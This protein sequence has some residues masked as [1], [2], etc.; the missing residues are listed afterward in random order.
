MFFLVFVLFLDCF[1]ICTFVQNYN[2]TVR[3]YSK[4]IYAS[5]RRPDASTVHCDGFHLITC[6][7]Q[8]QDNGHVT[9]R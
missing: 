6:H 3:K 8:T 5:D 4:Y 7:L 9:I 2:H 1:L